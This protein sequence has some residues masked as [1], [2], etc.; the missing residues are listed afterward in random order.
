[1]DKESKRKEAIEKAMKDLAE[2]QQRLHPEI[3]E[4]QKI[5]PKK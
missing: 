1:M 3:Y 4:N 5:D 2:E